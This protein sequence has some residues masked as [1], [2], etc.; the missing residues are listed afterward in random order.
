M[1]HQIS[2]V[3]I[4]G[5]RSG[6]AHHFNRGRTAVLFP[7]L[8]LSVAV[9]RSV[10]ASAA[11]CIC[12]LLLRISGTCLNRALLLTKPHLEAIETSMYICQ[13]E[14]RNPIT[15]HDVDGKFVLPLLSDCRPRRSLSRPGAYSQSFPA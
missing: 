7:L 14:K 5:H 15:Q 4:A 11:D 13:H 6:G 9:L 10:A 1:H 3:H 2:C 8:L 12:T